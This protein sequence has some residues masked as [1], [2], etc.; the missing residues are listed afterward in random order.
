MRVGGGVLVGAAVIVS[1]W[2][3]WP[4]SSASGQPEPLPAPQGG[5]AFFAG[6]ASCSA[7]GCH[8]ANGPQGTERSEFSTWSSWDKHARAYAVLD[9]DRSKRIVANLYPRSTKRATEQELCLKC[10]ATFDPG[11]PPGERAYMGDGVSCE[12]CHGP[13]G[14]T[15]LATH[16]ERGFLSKTPEQ[17]AKQ[18]LWP[19]KNL[20]FRTQLC[21]S[22]HVG[23]GSKEVNHDLIAAGHPRLNFEMA[24]YHAIYHK[25][26]NDRNYRDPSK[27]Q[28]VDFAAR[29]WVLGQLTTARAAVELTAIRAKHANEKG[30]Q[31]RPWPEFAEYA[32]FSCHQD[33]TVQPPAEE[34][35][36]RG[37]KYADR[38]T[39]GSFPYGTWYLS[40]V[41]PLARQ[42]G[43]AEAAVPTEIDELKKLMAR[44][45]GK[46]EDVAK[47]AGE[48]AR[49]LDKLINKVQGGP[50]MDPAQ[51]RAYFKA[52]V[53][54]GET[55]AAAMNW[56]DATQLYL[57][58]AAFYEAMGDR[59]V[60]AVTSGRL[61]DD[62][63]TIKKRL[64][65]AF[66]PGVDSPERFNPVS[67]P[68]SG[69]LR[70]LR[71]QLGN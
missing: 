45:G 5:K 43:G 63:Q 66:P 70:S 42:I 46:P 1:T 36:R 22:C 15:Y 14:N 24:G 25:H 27:N 53:Q 32:C 49:S 48:L 50:V 64:R 23:N 51:L 9:N 33:L 35:K 38:Q 59:G 4:G 61:K 37:A 62:M 41:D 20:S 54:N 55:R 28:P 17:K 30:P 11:I 16:Y 47:Q 52:F 8:N 34:L 31:G 26:W 10:H 40:M 7:S 21:T 13:A 68:L 12:A 6:A 67:P 18:G 58:L 56:D 44:P 39:P 71:E 60:S 29:L 19:T 57:S 69:Q 3:A 2:L 65:N